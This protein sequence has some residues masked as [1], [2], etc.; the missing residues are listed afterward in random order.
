[1]IRPDQLT[2]PN[3]T[4]SIIGKMLGAFVIWWIVRQKME[5]A[6]KRPSAET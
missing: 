1:M 3:I 6:P 5:G 2:G 4:M